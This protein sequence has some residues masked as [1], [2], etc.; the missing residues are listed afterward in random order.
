MNI[1][2]EELEEYMNDYKEEIEE[3]YIINILTNIDKEI[4]E[5]KKN[6]KNYEI[7]IENIEYNYEGKYKKIL[8]DYYKE[9]LENFK[10]YIGETQMT[11]WKFQ[12]LLSQ[13][14]EKKND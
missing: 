3:Q 4:E 8:L 9:S 6:I 1:D 5:N 13:E 12:T 2:K 11:F 7:A 14:K 10:N